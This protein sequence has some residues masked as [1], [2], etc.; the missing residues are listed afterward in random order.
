MS[1]YIGL[2]RTNHIVPTQIIADTQHQMKDLK[3]H[4]MFRHNYQT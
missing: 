1:N 4:T 3:K 2:S